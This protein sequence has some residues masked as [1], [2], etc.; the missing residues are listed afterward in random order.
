MSKATRR[1]RQ[2]AEPSRRQAQAA[3]L[4]AGESSTLRIDPILFGIAALGLGMLVAAAYFPALSAGF[5]WDDRAFTAAA[6]VQ[7]PAGIRRIWF[8][9][10]EIEGEGHYWPLT[11][12]TFWLEHRLWG[13]WAPGYHAVNL[14]LHFANAFLVW[15][16]LRRLN[17][18][19]VWAAWLAAA[20]FAVHPVHVE[21][22]AWIIGRKDL[23]ATLFYLGA[24]LAWLRT[25]DTAATAPWRRHLWHLLALALFAASL[26]CKSIGVTLPI[27]LLV[28]RWWAQG[29]LAVADCWRVAPFFAVAVGFGVADLFYYKEIID[30]DYALI[31]RVLIA[32][33]ALWFYVGKLLWPT[34]LMPIYP[35]WR[36]DLA[37]AAPWAY[38]L[39]ALAV[40]AMLWLLRGRIGRGAL[41]GAAF[42]AITLAPTLGLVP[43]G[44]MQFAFVA[45]R[46]QYLADIGAL[47][48]IVGAVTVAVGGLGKQGRWPAVG[49][50]AAL[51]IVLC[52]LTWQQAGIY[53]DEIV[54]FERVV[55]GNPSARDAHFNLGSALFEAGRQE[56]GLAAVRTSLA[57]RPESMK[58]QYGAGLMLYQ[59]GQLDEALAHL[60]RALAMNANNHV[61]QYATAM[62]LAAMGR[63]DEAQQHYR[64]SLQINPRHRPAHLKLAEL[65]ARSGQT[66]AAEEHVQQALTMRPDAPD[67]LLI[68]A[69]IE[70]NRQRYRAALDLFRRVADR[71]PGSA[72]AWSGIGAALYYLGEPDEALRHLDRALALD[73][74]LAEARNNRA[75]IAAT[76]TADAPRPGTVPESD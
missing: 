57:L 51:L 70:F 60:Q 61:V 71:R 62:V 58:A 65:L 55:A 59:L 66:A 34:E 41:A 6:A 46:Y 21:A 37:A 44:Y 16:L 13:F 52:T 40:A 3:T 42:F 63:G 9:P 43:F 7:E 26:L 45:N 35:H 27:A 20:L 72:R 53:R 25:L 30:V 68:L 24:A 8:S 47:T 11:Y 23:L 76:R 38:A 69:G 33:Q 22:V 15:H 10:S 5:V 32:A 31:E 19:P 56:E 17:A 48:V 29:R 36:V 14:L 49:V 54:F 2:P 74:S 12:T 67:A 64:R 50:A 73:P 18:L 28:Q 1:K 75:A 4:S 39:G